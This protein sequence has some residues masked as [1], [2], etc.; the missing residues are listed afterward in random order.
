MPREEPQFDCSTKALFADAFFQL[1]ARL[2]L[3]SSGSMN[4]TPRTAS[5][6]AN[7]RVSHS[8]WLFDVRR[9]GEPAARQVEEE[10][11]GCK[12]NNQWIHCEFTATRPLTRTN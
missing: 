2:P 10:H 6:I 5:A 8:T 4:P 1:A 12:R 11:R 7:W 9:G 3:K